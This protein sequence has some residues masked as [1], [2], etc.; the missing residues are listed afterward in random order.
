MTTLMVKIRF[1]LANSQNEAKI[2]LFQDWV[3]LVTFDGKRLDPPPCKDMISLA[4]IISLCAEI[5]ASVICLMQNVRLDNL[6]NPFYTK[7]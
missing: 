5:S 6:N 1:L 7:L 4:Q 3:F 2:K